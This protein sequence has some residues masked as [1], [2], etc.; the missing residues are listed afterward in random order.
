MSCSPFA[1][2]TSGGCNGFLTRLPALAHARDAQGKA[3]SQHA[4][5]CGNDEIARL[6]KTD[7]T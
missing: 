3:L 6:F 7:A 4:V 2:K 1:N 5:E